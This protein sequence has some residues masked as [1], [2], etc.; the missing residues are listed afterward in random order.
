MAEQRPYTF[1][2]V[3]RILIS[4]GILAGFGKEDF[5]SHHKLCLLQRVAHVVQVRVAGHG[6]LADDVDALYASFFGG[7]Q[8][9]GDGYYIMEIVERRQAQIPELVAV[10]Q[11][12]KDDL[13]RENFYSNPTEARPPGGETLKEVQIRAV[14]AVERV[15][16]DSPT[17]SEVADQF[18]IVSHAD[19]VRTIIAHYLHMELQTIRQ[20][21]ID[22]ASLTALEL[23]GLL[24]SLLFLNYHPNPPGLA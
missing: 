17:S 18:V 3:V 16:K 7:V 1:D 14:A 8:D 21:R 4:V 15:M 19:V 22:H 6:V 24:A 11:K 9:F 13:I 23:D 2:R 12:V 20:V 10:E 5:L